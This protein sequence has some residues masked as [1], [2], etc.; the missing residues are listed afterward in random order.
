MH[1]PKEQSLYCPKCNTHTEH[2][3]KQFKSGQARALSI[4]TRSN[5]RKHKKG[6]GGK[7]KFTATV[8]KQNKKPTFIAECAVCNR[9]VYRVI[10]KRMKKAELTAAA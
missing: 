6:Y 9:K 2:K 3:L 4:G 7:A 10:P 1:I 8:K 5:I